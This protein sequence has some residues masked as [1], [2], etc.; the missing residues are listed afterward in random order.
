[1][2]DTHTTCARVRNE[3]GAISMPLPAD[4]KVVSAGPSMEAW[5][6][7]RPLITK[8]YLDDNRELSE[9]RRIMQEDHD[10]RASPGMYKKRLRSWK[11]SKAL[12]AEEKTRLLLHL[13]Q[14]DLSPISDVRIDATVRRKLVRHFS[15][16]LR[17]S[18]SAAQ[19]EDTDDVESLPRATM[20]IGGAEEQSGRDTDFHQTGQL[21]QFLPL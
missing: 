10:F 13:A 7:Y 1:M 9:V 12:K 18:A 2:C 3:Q 16:L 15:T 5:E 8:L 20:Y 11:V 4:G 17:D 19:A 14:N 6:S 21:H